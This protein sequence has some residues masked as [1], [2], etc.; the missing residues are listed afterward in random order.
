VR[1]LVNGAAGRMGG[2][3]LRAVADEPSAVLAGALDAPGHP[4]VGEEVAPGVVLGDKPAEALAN[5]DVAIDFSL[6]AGTLALLE[7]ALPRGVPLVIA[8]TGFDAAGEQRLREATGRLAIVRAAN[9]SLGI[10]VMLDLVAEA[11]RRLPGY[12]L[13]VV[14]MHHDRKVDAPSG[15][16]LRIAE[17]AASARGV[18]LE[19]HAIYH[20]EGLTGPRPAGAIGMQSIRLGDSV[21]EHTLYLGGPG[22]RLEISH[23]ALSRDNFAAGALRAASW[24]VGRPP[25]LYSMTDVLGE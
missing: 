7:A 5:V 8:T 13:E 9:Y 22:E 25:G 6:P 17:A 19:E 1:V 16:A 4:R 24:V 14:E 12:E 23:R 2:H 10:H 21:G 20:R 11:A 15:T 3:V 18:R